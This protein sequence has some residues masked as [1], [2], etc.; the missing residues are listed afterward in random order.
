MEIKLTKGKVAIIDDSDAEL[1]LQYSWQAYCLGRATSKRWYAGTRERGT[2]KF[3]YMHRLL[4]N[5][6][7]DVKVDHINKNSLD[8]RKTNLRLC[9]LSQNNMNRGPTT[10]KTSRYKGVNWDKNRNKWQ[11]RIRVDSKQIH[12]GRFDHEID[13]A[14]AYDAMAIKYFGEFAFLNFGGQV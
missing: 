2:N 7:S 8:N 14:K 10:T 5:A 1:V 4:I 12:I 11:A 9:T 13:A 3:I 6:P